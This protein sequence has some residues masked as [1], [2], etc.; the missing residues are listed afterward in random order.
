MSMIKLKEEKAVLYALRCLHLVEGKSDAGISQRVIAGLH[1]DGL[2]TPN[3]ALTSVGRML[4]A[5]LGGPFPYLV[6]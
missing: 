4:L 1:D 2:V 6:R 5:D 3:G